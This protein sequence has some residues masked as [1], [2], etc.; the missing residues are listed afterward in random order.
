MLDDGRLT[1]GQGRTV[2]FRSTILI[3]TSNLGAH[4]LQDTTLTEKEKHDKVMQV[5]RASFKP[6]FLN[7]LDDVVVFDALQ[8][9]ELSRIVALQIDAVAAR[10]ADRRIR[11]DVDAASTAWLADAG[12]DPMYGARPL[13]RLVQKEIGDGLA[14][15]ILRGE[16]H[17][18][19]T[20]DVRVADDGSGLTLRPR[21]EESAA[22]D[23][24]AAEPGTA[25]APEAGRGEEP[26]SAEEERV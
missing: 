9:E 22:E 26:S 14:R 23:A 21:D 1:D 13:K 24:V 2:D 16:V 17:D 4:V 25:D 10:L 3:L 6:E 8:R 18:D 11:L 19:T 12:F 7:R 15:L 5:V 20:V